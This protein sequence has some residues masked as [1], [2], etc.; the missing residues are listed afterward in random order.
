[1]A[2]DPLQSSLELLY[3]ISRQLVS[4]LDLQ[5]VLENVITLSI[6]SP[7]AAMCSCST[8]SSVRPKR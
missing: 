2:F 6:R 5:T 1:M 7:N 4:S 8:A 3:N